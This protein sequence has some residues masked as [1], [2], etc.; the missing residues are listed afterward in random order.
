MLKEVM[1]PRNPLRYLP[2]NYSE[3]VLVFFLCNEER[4]LKKNTYTPLKCALK[5]NI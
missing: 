3:S 1:K 5:I 2:C 4:N